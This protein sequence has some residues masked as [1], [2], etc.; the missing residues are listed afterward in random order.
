MWDE[1]IRLFYWVNNEKIIDSGQGYYL[2][3]LE[4]R[5]IAAGLADESQKRYTTKDT[6]LWLSQRLGINPPMS[7]VKFIDE[8]NWLRC[9]KRL[10]RPDDWIPPI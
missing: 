7:I 4:I 10:Q 9:T 1:K 5:K 6:A 2:F 3:L 8:Y